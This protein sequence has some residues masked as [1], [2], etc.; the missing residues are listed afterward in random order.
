MMKGYIIERVDDLTGIKTGLLEQ[1]AE[2]KK[3]GYT[4]DPTPIIPIGF[5]IPNILV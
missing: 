2:M 5:S 4:E 3:E 1:T